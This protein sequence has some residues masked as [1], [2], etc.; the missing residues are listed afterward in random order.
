[1]GLTNTSTLHFSSLVRLTS[2][3]KPWKST[4]KNANQRSFRYYRH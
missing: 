1:M 3:E 2:G 4:E